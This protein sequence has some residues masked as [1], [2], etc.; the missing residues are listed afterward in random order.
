M[1]EYRD[2]EQALSLLRADL[3]NPL[4]KFQQNNHYSWISN[5]SDGDNQ[6]RYLK[7]DRCPATVL[8][9]FRHPESINLI[10]LNQTDKLH[11]EANY[12]KTSESIRTAERE[13]AMDLPLL[14]DETAGDAKILNAITAIGNC[15]RDDIFYPYRPL[16]HAI[17]RIVLQR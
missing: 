7:Q 8:R 12:E 2:I 1:T 15:R 14:L 3:D 4:Q 13:F 10:R 5:N 11:T 17:R 6:T 16:N 9:K